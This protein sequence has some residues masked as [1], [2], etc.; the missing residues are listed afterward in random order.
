[1]VNEFVRLPRRLYRDD[2][3][4]VMPLERDQRE[5]LDPHRH[6]FYRHG[7]AAAWLA[8]RDGNAVGRI[9]VSDDPRYNEQQGENLGCFG[10]FE[11]IDD[12]RV[13]HELFAA[14]AGWLANRGRTRIRGPVDFSINYPLGLLVEGFRAPPRIMMNHNPPYYAALLES[15]GLLKAKDLYAWWF[16]GE[17][18]SLDRWQQRVERLAKRGGIT[19]R[20]IR[21]KD[22]DAEMARCQQVYNRMMSDHWGFVKMTPDEFAHMAATMR[23]MVIPGLVLMAEIGGEPVGFS[24]TL[25][26]WNEALE[27]IDG[28]LTR[29]GLPIPLAKLLYHSR[30]IKTG[31]MAV[32]GVDQRFRRRGV[33][34][35]LILNTF[36]FGKHTLG[37]TGAELSWTLEDNTLINRTIEAVGGRRYKTYRVFERSLVEP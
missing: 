7:S 29:W 25:P 31:R 5:M 20:P 13:A 21:M 18:P 32:L 23:P 14:A 4:W 28:R 16:D 30:R 22:F 3:A 9:L 34:E 10:M 33:A 15:W 6:P 37:Y 12:V 11:C 19:V 26:D 36:R 8:F 24:L 27:K 2:P 35:L 1:M 17:S